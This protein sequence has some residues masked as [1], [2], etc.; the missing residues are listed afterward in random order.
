MIVGDGVNDSLS[1][2]KS[3]LS[4]AVKGSA[5]VSLRV[6][7]I[8]ISQD[9]L[10]LLEKLFVLSL[11]TRKIILRNLFLSC[12]YNITGIILSLMGYIS[13]LVA[14]IAMPISSLTVIGLTLWA[15]PAFRSLKKEPL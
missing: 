8:Y 12:F 7:D 6:A 10:R 2:A 11:E 4:I 14:A 3:E 9:D 13:P 15:T 1:M 5:D